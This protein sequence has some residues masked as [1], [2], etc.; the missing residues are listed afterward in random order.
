M[1]FWIKVF[2]DNSSSDFFRAS[3]FNF[4]IYIHVK[5]Q[6]KFI[7]D[8]EVNKNICKHSLHVQSKAIE[9]K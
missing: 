7:N 3:T 9:K 1:N 2:I 8:K 4:K 5:I 6:M